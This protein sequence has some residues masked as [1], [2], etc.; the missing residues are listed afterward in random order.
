MSSL[1]EH[2]I[3]VLL[4]DDQ[5]MIGEAVRRMLA[6][7]SD[8]IFYYCSD[9]TEAVRVACEVKPTVILQDLVM[10][11]LDGLTL[12]RFF[13]ANPAT[14]NIPMIV[15]SS[16]E[17]PR[18]KSEAFGYGANDYMVKLPDKLEVLARIRYHSRAYINLLQRDEA[19][20]ALQ[21]SQ[22]KLEKTNEFIRKTFGRYL[23]DE[24]VE[25]LLE[26]PD[27]LNLGG[28]KKRLTIMM[29]DLRGFTAIGETLKPEKVV[30]IIN[31]F[32]GI[33]TGIIHKYQGTIDEFI[34]DAILAIFGAPVSYPDDSER[35][36][37]CAIEMQLAMKTVNQINREAG[38]PD[39]HMG[40]GL[41]TGEVVVGNIGSE[42]RAKYGVVGRH[43]NLTSRVESYTVGGQIMIS[44]FTRNDIDIELRIDS[45]MT[46][47]PKGVKQPIKIYEIGGIGGRHQLYLPIKEPEVFVPLPGPFDLQFRVLEG[48]DTGGNQNMGQLVELSDCGGIITTTTA[49]K[50]LQNLKVTLFNQDHEPVTNELYC[51]VTGIDNSTQDRYFL[52]FTS[53]PAEAESLLQTDSVKQKTIEG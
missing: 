46:V 4:I 21:L 26:K 17:E 18:I 44:E 36:I 9:P 52:N 50:P 42:L 6:D 31:N 38:L 45:E 40:I 43:V 30:A 35:A 3:T 14:R 34:G 33:M 16:K 41:N 29:T 23:S 2:K 32:L 49:L 8:I 47:E 20:N 51:K 10:P 13:R 22:K 19:Y 15:L 7:E 27:G 5:A 12:V 37:A 1:T 53:I 25:G 28:E 24:I 48:K 11:Q 39:V